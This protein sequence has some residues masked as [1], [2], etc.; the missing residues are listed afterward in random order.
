MPSVST[1]GS[2]DIATLD[3]KVV[4]DLCAGK[5]YVDVSPSQYIGSGAD[6][7]QGANVQIKNPWGTIVK[8]YGEDFEIN[9]ALSGG[10][11]TIIAYNIPTQAGVFQFGTYEVSVELT[12][13]EGNSW[14]VTKPVKVCE[15]DRKNK[16]RNY[17]TLSAT[18]NGSCKQG[19]LFIL[20]DR[21]PTYGG[22]IVSSQT[23]EF[24]LLYP[25]ASE[26]DP[27]VTS[28][29]AFAVQLFEGV[30]QISGEI[31]AEYNFG[32]NV[33][34]KVKYKVK[35]E[36]QIRCLIDLCCVF[37][38]LKALH[39]KLKSDCTTAEKE[40]T[41]NII[42]DTLRLVE[43]IRI[44]ADCDGEDVSEYITDLEKLLGCVCTCN[45]A[46]GT[47]V[48]S[49]T[50]STDVIIQ[51]CNVDPEVAGL[52]TT[53]TIDNFA[54]VVDIEPNG[55][56]MT[57]AG[58]TLDGCTKTQKIT[59]NI[60]NAY[61]A[62]K[63][64]ANQDNT[65]ADSWA[66][67][68]NKALRDINPSCLGLTDLQWQNKTLAQKFSAVFTRLCSCCGCA[69]EISDV[70]TEQVG[71]G[72]KLTWTN[73]GDVFLVNVYVDDLL[74]GTVLAATEEFTVPNVAGGDEKTYKLVPVCS[75]GEFGTAV[76]GTFF[77]SGCPEIPPV[78][79]ATS[80]YEV[81]CPFDLEA[82][83]GLTPGD[84]E[85]H[86]QN[87]TLPATLVGNPNAVNDG[88]YYVFNRQAVGAG[89]CYSIGTKVTVICSAAE[90]CT[91]P[92]NLVASVKIDGATTTQYFR[93][94]GAAYP[95]PAN[96][97]TAKRRLASDPDSPGSYTTIGTPVWNAG[98]SKWEF[99]DDI[100][101]SE[102][103][104]LYVYRVE[105]NCGGSPA[106][107][108]YVDLTYA[109]F[110][111]GFGISYVP[112]DDSIEYSIIT[113]TLNDV[114]KVE[115]SLYNGATLVHTDTYTPAIPDPITGT[116][117]Y[118]DPGTVY[119]I[120][121]KPFMGTLYSNC[122][123]LNATTTGVEGGG[124][125]EEGR[126]IH[127]VNETGASIAI[128]TDISTYHFASGVNGDIVVLPN[129]TFINR[130]AATWKFTFLQSMPATLDGNES[131]NPD[132]LA[133]NVGHTIDSDISIL[134]YVRVAAP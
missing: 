109:A 14:T 134:N 93:F 75:N 29:G 98:A 82:A 133:P 66:A 92:Q 117:E 48:I 49:G 111:C 26:L 126:H 15:P 104:K 60:G 46:E 65:E 116:F 130:S 20:V 2:P 8:P 6:N 96:S 128:E 42:F 118:L 119:T 27:L 73:N 28:S 37:T 131:P 12:D 39:N 47:P 100:S 112:T 94:D 31:C 79:V 62:I 54:Y 121:V 32:D 124:D 87:N 19:K 113:G 57:I 74:A 41:Q 43:M 35:K 45:C 1:T 103:N 13:S 102:Y 52:T 44:S 86:N 30:Y 59:F 21:V 95:P 129:G 7:V 64:L 18:M 78:S 25:T 127:I 61:N 76:D 3:S 105:S 22:K 17:G 34:V 51:G 63:A 23:Q 36:K 85:L 81:E 125:E 115:V 4:A 69:A 40:E 38:Q 101:G 123:Q 84:Y 9:P 106:T 33:S 24:T 10:M 107:T 16:Q 71:S 110:K 114:T 89:Y 68:I 72:V 67:I 5:F 90:S 88:E 83:L 53:Y 58:A 56:I 50:P 108:P 120:K 77:F 97:Y 132:T 55:G 122:D 99:S 80:L 70:D 11:D 91:A